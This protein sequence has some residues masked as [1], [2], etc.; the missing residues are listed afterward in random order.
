MEIKP[1]ALL[2]IIDRAITAREVKKFM[3]DK[4]ELDGYNHWTAKWNTYLDV[5]SELTG[6]D[7]LEFLGPGELE[8]L[9]KELGNEGER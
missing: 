4:E 2:N 9:R 7:V 6:R 5:L 3:G 1:N 8:K